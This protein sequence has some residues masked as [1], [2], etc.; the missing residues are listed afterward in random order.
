MTSNI[1]RQ[2]MHHDITEKLDKLG[3]AYDKLDEQ[4]RLLQKKTELLI[5]R[6]VEFEGGDEHETK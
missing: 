1:R 5:K 4:L 3:L 6:I 2:L